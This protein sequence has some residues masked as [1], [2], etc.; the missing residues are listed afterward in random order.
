MGKFDRS[1]KL[2]KSSFRVIK[3]DPELFA[4]VI[5]SSII[6]F[7]VLLLFLLPIIFSEF[8][9]A[10]TGSLFAEL[11]SWMIYFIL[12][13]CLFLVGTFFNFAIVYTTANRFSGHNAKFFE[14]L[15]FAFSKLHLIFLW[16]LVSATVG[17]I[18][19]VLENVGKRGGVGA[20]ISQI[21]R[22]ILGMAWTISTIFVIPIMVYKGYGPVKSIKQSV[23]T[24]KKTWG[25]YLIKGVGFGLTLLTFLF[26]GLIIGI[27]LAVLGFMING[28]LGGIMMLII[29]AYCVILFMIFGLMN[30]VYNTALYIYAET[31]HIPQEFN[32]NQLKGSF[33]H[34]KRSTIK[35]RFT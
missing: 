2:A 28:L 12:Y 34:S 11:A 20:I 25:E 18:L 17:I 16:S 29:V 33:L 23:K 15:K 26:V 35:S 32:E 1:W 10:F 21:S 6:S 13:L 30:Q 24:L 9:V 19:K 3:K 14:S 5:L 22:F 27:P 31:G 4:Y 8:Y 7:A